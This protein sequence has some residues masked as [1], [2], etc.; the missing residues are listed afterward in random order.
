MTKDN[1]I[2]ELKEFHNHHDNR[3]MM[4]EHVIKGITLDTN[5]TCVTLYDCAI[6]KWLE[7]RETLLHKIYG[8]DSI[9]E[10]HARHEEWHDESEKICQ[11]ATL[12][13][14]RS[15][16]VLAKVFGKKNLKIREGE[17]DIAMVYLSNLK[18]LTSTIDGTFVRMLKRA[19]A[20]HEEIFLEE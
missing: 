19:N 3:L 8:S 12:K 2:S 20:L 14:Q 17:Y 7:K 4:I 5:T 10:L 6:Y 15:Q 11:L 13:G 16:G 1:F 18:E 9:K